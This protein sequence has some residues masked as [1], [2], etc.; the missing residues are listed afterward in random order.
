MPQPQ[1]PTP[2]PTVQEDEEHRGKKDNSLLQQQIHPT[3]D[4]VPAVHDDDEEE[5]LE[6]LFGSGRD[7]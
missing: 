4:V 6:R 2:L 7:H 3:V 5:N 1:L